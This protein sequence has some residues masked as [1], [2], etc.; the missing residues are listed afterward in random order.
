MALFHRFTT[1][2]ARNPLFLCLPFAPFAQRTG[3]KGTDSMWQLTQRVRCRSKHSWLLRHMFRQAVDIKRKTVSHAWP[4]P[5]TRGAAARRGTGAGGG[6]ESIWVLSLFHLLVSLLVGLSV[7]F[8]C[9]VFLPPSVHPS[10]CVLACFALLCF[11]LL[12][13]ALLAFFVSFLL[14]FPPPTHTCSIR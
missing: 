6:K 8:F 4:R 12:C 7:C 5:L 2:A 1:T 11:A 9:L 10:A 13:F 3:K 14:F